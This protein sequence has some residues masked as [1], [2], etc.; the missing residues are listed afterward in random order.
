MEIV[1]RLVESILAE[2]EEVSLPA[3]TSQ[4]I[5]AAGRA[6][7]ADMSDMLPHHGVFERNQPQAYASVFAKG[8]SYHTGFARETP[9]GNEK[10]EKRRNNDAGVQK[11]KPVSDKGDK[12]A[13]LHHYFANTSENRRSILPQ[14]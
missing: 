5:G 9:P 13:L 8:K 6:V 3:N 7:Q 11:L 12:S 14:G 4:E 10:L 2:L 1:D